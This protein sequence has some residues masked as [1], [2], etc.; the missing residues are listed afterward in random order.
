M[1]DVLNKYDKNKVDEKIVITSIPEYIY[2]RN[3]NADLI[4]ALKIPF[5][6]LKK[7]HQEM[8]KKSGKQMNYLHVLNDFLPCHFI[9]INVE[10]SRVE[11]LLRRKA[12]FVMSKYSKCKNRRQRG[13]LD[14]EVYTLCLRNH[15]LISFDEVEDR[16]VTKNK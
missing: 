2:K 3:D 16:A 12:G 9:K 5:L 8:K 13:K 10:C 15:E 4:L 11:E 7:W 1:S 14:K 6:C